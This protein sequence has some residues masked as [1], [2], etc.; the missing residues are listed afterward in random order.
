[1]LSPAL[2]LLLALAILVMG[3]LL[4]WPPHGF[5]WRWR[6]GLLATE[7]VL[8][9]DALK[10][11]HG[12]EFAE[13][14]ATLDSVAGALGVDRDR[15]AELLALLQ[16][17]GLATVS[18]GRWTLSSEGRSY[19]L[20]VVRT[21]RLWERYFSEE[22]GVPAAEW[23]AQAEIR[24]HRTTSEETEEL[25]A[26]L[27]HPR[28]DPHGDPIPTRDGGMPVV[29][30]GT[31]LPQLAPGSLA[32]IV[33]VE[34]EPEAVYKQLI[35]EGLHP[36]M[37]VL[38]LEVGPERIRFEADAE[39]HVLAPVVAGNLSVRERPREE[40]PR[41]YESLAALGPGEIGI[42]VSLS[43]AIH[44]IERRRLLD[45]G[46]VPGT[47]VA[48]VRRGPGGELAAYRIRGAVMALRDDQAGQVRIERPA[49]ATGVAR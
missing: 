3:V 47:E 24:E 7:R 32:E 28:F 34:D 35:A 39:E 9:E 12:C 43:P 21:H 30:P 1:M 48:M 40:M 17:E 45:L 4:F 49:A 41:S 27:G 20:R 23:H 5:W 36:G 14:E 22:T 18:H 42:V 13:L 31:P 25:S 37:R 6:R 26:R 11:L 8:L 44:G 2:L 38:M 10:H 15:A 19:A 29:A 33:H 16:S 46:L